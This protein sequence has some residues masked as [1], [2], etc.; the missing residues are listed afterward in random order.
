MIN[1]CP[2]SVGGSEGRHSNIASEIKP[3][4]RWALNEIDGEN[5]AS[6]M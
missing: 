4:R 1:A 3:L 5:E 2:V 6:C